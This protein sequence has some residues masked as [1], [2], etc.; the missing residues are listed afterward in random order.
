MVPGRIIFWNIQ[1]GELI[2]VL[3][4]ITIGILV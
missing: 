4:T 1:F 2:Y 3:A